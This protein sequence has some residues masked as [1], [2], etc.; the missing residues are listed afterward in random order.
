MTKLPLDRVEANDDDDSLVEDVV[1]IGRL[2]RIF[3]KLVTGSQE[4]PAVTHDGDHKKPGGK[5][6]DIGVYDR[7]ETEDGM[8]SGP[9][10]DLKIGHE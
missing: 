2:A 1:R 5:T 10:G 8:P 3:E 9:T 4:L 7:P 6:D